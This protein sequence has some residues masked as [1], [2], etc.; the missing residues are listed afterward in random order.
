MAASY[1]DMGSTNRPKPGLRF[2][3][4]Q[5]TVLYFLQLMVSDRY[6]FAIVFCRKAMPHLGNKL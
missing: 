2:T 5:P 6:A 3:P 1:M 4:S